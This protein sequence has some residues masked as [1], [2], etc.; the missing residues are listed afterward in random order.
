LRVNSNGAVVSP[1]A[2]A[3][4][5]T[6]PTASVFSLGASISADTNNSGWTFVAYLFA[7]L[8]GISKVGSYTGTGTTLLYKYPCS[9]QNFSAAGEFTLAFLK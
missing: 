5:S 3:W 9:F 7:T 8:P 4:N 6:T 2:Y 1:D